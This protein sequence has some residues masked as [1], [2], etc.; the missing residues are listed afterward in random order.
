MVIV[1]CDM[2]RECPL[3]C[4][5]T[6]ATFTFIHCDIIWHWDAWYLTWLIRHDIVDISLLYN[7][8]ILSFVLIYI[9]FLYIQTCF[10]FLLGICSLEVLVAMYMFLLHWKCWNDWI[11]IIAKCHTQKWKAKQKKFKLLKHNKTKILCI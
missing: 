9:L 10:W 2:Y 5:G 6:C 4:S 8:H 1:I 7:F 3:N 11:E